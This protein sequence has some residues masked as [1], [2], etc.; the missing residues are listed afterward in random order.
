[1]RTTVLY[2]KASVEKGRQKMTHFIKCTD[3]KEREIFPAKIKHRDKIRHFTTKFSASTA[4]ANIMT[5]DNDKLTRALE[6]GETPSEEQV[7]D[8]EPYD[9]MMEMLIL[10]FGEK[11][12]AEQI[13]E[14]LDV[15][16]ISEI[17]DV[18]YG[19]SGYKKKESEKKARTGMN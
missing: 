6:E 2:W 12:T 4:I 9:A 3:G 7:F 17:L 10:A 11:Y 8:N 19:L 15:E 14:F 5:I 16:M 13:E 1:M 18:F